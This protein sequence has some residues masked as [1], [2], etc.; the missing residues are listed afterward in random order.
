VLVLLGDG[1]DLPLVREAAARRGLLDRL[2]FLGEVPDA[3]TVTAACDVALFPSASESFGLAALEAMACGAPVVASRIG[4]LPEV[5]AHGETGYLE[6]VGDVAA[7]AAR[8]QALLD[9][10][11]LRQR[12]GEAAV[13]RTTELFSLEQVLRQHE[14]LY[15]RLA[16]D[17]S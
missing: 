8:T 11:A 14:A 3:E 10:S 9:D 1:P 7:M 12:C 2:R 4:G 5:V 6:P 17:R 13:R 16:H 15:E